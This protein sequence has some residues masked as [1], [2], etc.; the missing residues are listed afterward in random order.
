[1]AIAFVPTAVFCVI[2]GIIIWKDRKKPPTSA[3]ARSLN[4]VFQG[5]GL[6]NLV[7]AF[8]FGYG[9]AKAENFGLWLYHPIVVCMFQGVA[10]YVA[11]N[12]MRQAWLALVAAGWFI[13]TITLGIAVFGDIGA[14]LLTLGLALILLMAVPGAVIW[15]RA[16]K[17]G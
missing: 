13:T 3:A 17:S 7:M 16:K 5:A 1:M 9:A 12:I 14:Y 15:R 8:V 2:L 11:W 6:A 4:A 10:W